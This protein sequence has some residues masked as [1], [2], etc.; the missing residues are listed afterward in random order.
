MATP[1]TL[2]FMMRMK[3]LL[4]SILWI[5]TVVFSQPVQFTGMAP[6]VWTGVTDHNGVSSF[7]GLPFAAPPV[8]KLRW[9]PPQ[10]YSPRRRSTVAKQYPP[11][12]MQGPD[13]VDWY[14]ELISSIGKNPD[15]FDNPEGGYSEDC[16]YL[17][18]WTANMDAKKPAKKPVMVWIHGGGNIGGWSYEPDYRGHNLAQEDVVVVS[19][20]YRLGIFGNFSHPALLKAQAGKAGNYGLLDLIA[21]LKWIQQYIEEFGGDPNNVTIFGESAGAA[22]IGYLLSSPQAKGLFHR[23]IHQSAGYEL[24][25]T[26]TIS[27]LTEVGLSIGKITN[28]N[29]I[30]ALRAQTSEDLLNAISSLASPP[31]FDPVIRGHALPKSPKEIFQSASQ[32][33]VPL[34]IG[35]N[36]HEWLMYISESDTVDKHLSSYKLSHK[37]EA[38]EASLKGL[39]TKSKLDRIS[40]AVEMLCPSISM[41]TSVS[42]QQSAYAY[43]LTRVRQ[44]E[45][46]QSVGAYHGA[47][48]PYVFNTHADWLETNAHDKTLTDLMQQYWVNFARTGNPN[49]EGLPQWQSFDTKHQGVLELGDQ[50]QMIRAPDLALCKI[51]N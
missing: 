26:L 36:A 5:P 40:T 41:A 2:K 33:N 18:I 35:T 39:D 20:A 22:N 8:G 43:Q 3:F 25:Q 23:A 14:K 47:E 10:A 21:G 32:I 51:I 11:T 13:L 17:N 46:W 29:T 44:G 27:E 38:I 24:S 31:Q 50:V 37:K 1:Q 9:H 42:H 48:I 7:K 19:I 16:L 45:H 30:A 28:S 12:C 15:I 34:M 4:L 49:H 6:E